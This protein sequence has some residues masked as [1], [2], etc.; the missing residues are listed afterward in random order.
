MRMHDYVS[1]ITPP[2]HTQNTSNH[3]LLTTNSTLLSTLLAAALLS[4][5]GQVSSAVTFGQDV[6]F[7]EPDANGWVTLKGNGTFVDYPGRYTLIRVDASG[8]ENEW[9][10]EDS[11]RIDQ[12]PEICQSQFSIQ[13]IGGTLTLTGDLDYKVTADSA[14]K[15]A[16]VFESTSCKFSQE[17]LMK[18][19]NVTLKSGGN[20]KFISWRDINFYKK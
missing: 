13:T 8:S 17:K 14:A 1:G 18:S 15:N 3:H 11:L 2:H 19:S 12:H 4:I 7:S 6:T 16:P 9:I 10:F 20:F 5:S